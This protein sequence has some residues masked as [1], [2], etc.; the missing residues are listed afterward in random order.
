MSAN[1]P[2]GASHT[3]HRTST[4]IASLSARKNESSVR[5]ASAGGRAIAS[6]R[7]S[8]KRRSGSIA[9]FA[10]AATGLVGI[11]DVS[12]LEKPTADTPS[13]TALAASAA[14]GRQRRPDSDQSR[15]P[16]ERCYAE[17]DGDD[18]GADQHCD[19]HRQCAASD[20]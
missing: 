6:A 4:S 9:P 20:P 3:I 17:R 19:E 18:G 12:Q 15:K 10:A 1:T 5:R 7:N 11:S 13:E 16:G 8:V 2:I 14:P